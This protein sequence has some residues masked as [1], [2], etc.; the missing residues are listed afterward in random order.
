[1]L[2]PLKTLEQIIARLGETIDSLE[3]SRT[4]GFASL[5]LELPHGLSRAPDLPG[6]QFQFAHNHRGEVRAGYGV[7]GEWVAQGDLRLRQLQVIAKG[8]SRAWQHQDPDETGFKGFAMLGFAASPDE[9]PEASMVDGH[10]LPNALLWIPELALSSRTGQSAVILTTA[11]PVSRERAFSR[12]K[13]QLKR[14]IP[15]L[16]QPALAPL[17]PAHLDHGATIPDFRHWKT[18]VATALQQI[19]QA[20]L[21]KVVICRRLR[22]HGHRRFDLTRLQAALAYL[23][24]SCQVVTIRRHLASF[25]AATPER[26]LTQQRG[27]VEV[28][29]IAGTACRAPSAARDAQL[30]TELQTSPKNLRE[31]NVVVDAVV[32]ALRQC[33]RRIERPETPQVMQLNNAQ[34]LWTMIRAEL[35]PGMDVFQLAELLHPTPATNGQP[36]ARARAWL[37]QVEPFQRGWYTGAA[38]ILEPDLTGELWVLLR[39]ASI[40]DRTADLFAGAGI[41]AGSDAELEWQE[42]AHKLAAMSSALQFA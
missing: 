13:E 40:H 24:P 30:T 23:F 33:S 39:C 42:T 3:L 32:D 2:A 16:N 14:T 31:H 10:S 34:H 5:V 12:W 22:L 19:D 36:C 1:M 41:V 11:L 29:A 37:R 27:I 4:D 26:L 6:P 15:H 7:A 35:I 9:R 28:D 20:R 21:E 17:T 18:L 38:G 8:I 25:V